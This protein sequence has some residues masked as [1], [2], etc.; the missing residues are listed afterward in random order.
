[1]MTGICR[2]FGS[3]WSVRVASK[4]FD[5]HENEV[6]LKPLGR[7]HAL[8]AVESRERS[9]AA[10]LE[11]T[12]QG[13]DNGAGIVHDQD[14]RVLGSLG[15]VVLTMPPHPCEDILKRVLFHATR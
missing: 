10:G 6:W 15:R 1:M 12:L 8:R 11:H 4:P 14:G 7:V 2:V 9:V 13:D 5:V 3:V